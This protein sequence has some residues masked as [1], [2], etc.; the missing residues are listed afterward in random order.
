MEG[1]VLFLTSCRDAMEA[2]II[3]GALADMGIDCI[4]QGEN[5]SQ[6]YG[7]IGAMNVRLLVHE[8]DYNRAKAF[9]DSR[10]MEQDPT[11]ATLEPQQPKSTSQMLKECL[12]FSTFVSLCYVALNYFTNDDTLS[13]LAEKGAMQFVGLFIGYFVLKWGYERWHR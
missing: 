3:K 12:V 11:Y 7:G 10:E 5:I 6:I 8:N 1:K 4:L 9:L 13:E 2:E